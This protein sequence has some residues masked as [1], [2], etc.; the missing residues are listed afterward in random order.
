MKL[1]LY[2]SNHIFLFLGI[3]LI[4]TLLM[5][6]A[7]YILLKKSKPKK[8]ARSEAEEAALNKDAVA[9][10]YD[11]P[12]KMKASFLNSIAF[13]K[14]RVSGKDF[15]YRTPWFV[16]IGESQVGKTTLLMNTGLGKPMGNEPVESRKEKHAIQWWFFDRGVVIEPNGEMVLKPDGRNFNKSAWIY[17]LKL[18]KKHRPNRPLDGV[19]LTI[20]CKDLISNM[21][22]PAELNQRITNKALYLHE[23][24]W[25]LQK[26]LGIHFPVY[27]LFTK[28]DRIVGFKSLCQELPNHLMDNIVGWSNPNTLDTSYSGTWMDDAVSSL[29]SSLF[30]TQMEIFTLNETIDCGEELL[31]LPENVNSLK[32][33]I[34]LFLNTIFKES[35]YH[36]S[37]FFRGIY[38]TGN[39][40][41]TNDE[42]PKPT[43]LK[44]LFEEKIFSEGGIA[45]LVDQAMLSKHRNR[46]I[47]QLVFGAIFLVGTSGLLNAFLNLRE[48][49]K[50][51]IPVVEIINDSLVEL[52]YKKIVNKKDFE[53][54]AVELLTK[55]T[56]VDPN[57]LTSAFLP[58]SW[59]SDLQSNLTRSMTAAYSK[60]IMRMIF[61]E[62][63][64]RANKIG[65]V[66]IELDEEK[67]EVGKSLKYSTEFKK[68]SRFVEKMADLEK[69][70]T[71]Y[72]DKLVKG[73]ANAR[74]FRQIV[75]Y[76]YD[77]DL[78][79]DISQSA[80]SKLKGQG[81]P[82]NILESNVEARIFALTKEFHDRAFKHNALNGKLDNLTNMLNNIR[83]ENGENDGS[84]I[85]VGFQDLLKN[86]SQVSTELEDQE[87]AWIGGVALELGS[88]YD[89]VM[90]S[91][92]ASSFLRKSVYPELKKRGKTGFKN[93]Q[94]NLI[95]YNTSLTGPILLQ[96]DAT[97]VLKFSEGVVTLKTVMEN[98]F[99]MK[100]AVIEKEKVPMR[101][102]LEK[103]QRLVWNSAFLKQ[104]V[105]LYE[106]YSAFVNE[107][108][109]NFPKELQPIFD[110]VAK[111]SLETNMVQL[112]VRAQKFEDSNKTLNPNFRKESLR[113]E[114]MNFRDVA[115]ELNKLLE[116]F[117]R[118]ELHE[119]NR[120][121]FKLI[122]IQGNRTLHAIDDLLK[123]ESL[124]MVRDGNFQ[125][126]DGR[127]SPVFEAYNVNGN[128][129]LEIYFS[130][131]RGLIAFLTKEFANPI[132]SFLG[133]K[134]KNRGFV[135]VP[136][137]NK[138]ERIITSYDLY[139][140][141]KPGNTLDVLEKFIVTE[142]NTIVDK[143]C[144]T[145]IPS[146]I[147]KATSG[148][149]F[150]QQKNII[151]KKLHQ[152]CQMLAFAD[153]V[154]VY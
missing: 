60:I 61:L 111:E 127:K 154:K 35:A 28:S 147:L 125:W 141:K 91:I 137:V 103:N 106:P 136:L 13:L 40:D 12:A 34:K 63:K 130:V 77:I 108:L 44:H 87:N 32:N 113:I 33:P 16:M 50:I 104:A 58:S 18:L 56:D 6:W 49:E 43:F 82:K 100:F 69:N 37:F 66:D 114:V 39:R 23:K 75:E 3:L 132:V 14:K 20:D 131:Q 38:F 135:N 139:E 88:E 122:A 96:N 149:F 17:F 92:K 81:I 55:M 117:D 52:R 68:L 73:A 151:G 89:Q 128:E 105:K 85:V 101:S 142:I 72:N 133:Y 119:T 93:L 124:Y 21:E 116:I 42:D 48:E 107:K 26:E 36:K 46:R 86:L 94:S 146:H 78:P 67:A 53:S 71:I 54:Q 115:K 153:E 5:A 97:F 76:L 4:L 144:K 80:L 123:E 70:L 19:I 79:T 62:F 41:A 121:I 102:K 47:A 65:F 143:R 126:W 10:R 45:K 31:L 134:N 112:I 99:S 118:L 150:L 129:E 98:Y 84:N 110:R 138:W 152:R 140:K 90:D 74:E 83:Q 9:R 29:Q 120:A 109:H 145:E 25:E 1:L 148:D 30:R 27:I 2:F 22:G 24:L 11:S 59:A 95:A 8:K 57:R 64:N 15:K 51:I 7:F